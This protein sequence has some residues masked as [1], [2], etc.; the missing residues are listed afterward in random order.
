MNPVFEALEARQLLSAVHL[1]VSAEAADFSEGA[2]QCAFVIQADAPVA[3]DLPVTF[4]LG[5]SAKFGKDYQKLAR[6]AVIPAGAD[7]VRVVLDIIDDD[8][9]EPTE[10]VVLKLKKSRN[11]TA[12]VNA[13]SVNILDNEPILHLFV[14][15][16]HLSCGGDDN[17][18]SYPSDTQVA[19]VAEGAVKE[20]LT[21][22]LRCSGSAVS[23]KH[24]TVQSVNVITAGEVSAGA[25]LT[26][27]HWRYNLRKPKSDVVHANISLALSRKY[28]ISKS[29]S[30]AK[31]TLE[32]EDGYFPGD[33]WWDRYGYY[34][35]GYSGSV[36]TCYGGNGRILSI[37]SD[38][39]I[40]MGPGNTCSITVHVSDASYGDTTVHLYFGG[41]A[42]VG[43][44]V[45]PIA[46][47]VTIPAGQ[48][49]A[50]I[51]VTPIEDDVP[52]GIKHLYVSL[53]PITDLDASDVVDLIIVG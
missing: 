3:Q 31:V 42:V 22:K 36:T 20:D 19:V 38:D 13:A 25:T 50:T 16:K 2:G 23:G 43:K 12:D 30:S 29:D 35:Y 46:S 53:E 45:E 33:S 47:M 44:D 39:R 24:Y 28:H 37:D 14:Q 48:T 32:S 41:S 9:A 49:S 18:P 21:V 34:G 52:E 6:K 26:E 11:Y 8:L 27:Y 1:T 17:E 10:T 51:V 7:H 5:G 15:N 4:K 40:G